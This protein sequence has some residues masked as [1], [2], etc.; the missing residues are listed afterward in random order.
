VGCIVINTTLNKNVYD[1]VLMD[2]SEWDEILAYKTL[3]TPRNIE[4]YTSGF[5]ALAF[6]KGESVAMFPKRAI[7]T[8]IELFIIHEPSHQTTSRGLSSGTHVGDFITRDTLGVF[9]DKE[10]GLLISTTRI[11][12]ITAKKHDVLCIP[13]TEI[14]LN[15]VIEFLHSVQ[16]CKYNKWDTMLSATATLIPF[17]SVPDVEILDH[18]NI[19]HSVTSIHPSQ[20]VALITRHCLGHAS[21][22]GAKLWGF[23]S[24]LIN[25]D[26]I[27]EQLRGTCMA[28]HSNDLR[29]GRL[30]AL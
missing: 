11:N 29:M 30:R 28:V 22:V 26:E 23:N 9:V 12:N 24:R 21:P 17:I 14:Q 13:L 7:H 25:A 18:R 8:D 19:G 10:L 6:Q 1:S 5:M 16:G 2:S 20:L 15:K 4:N 27:Y 3:H